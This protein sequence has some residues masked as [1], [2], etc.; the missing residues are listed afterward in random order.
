[1]RLMI[2]HNCGIVGIS[3]ANQIHGIA[4]KVV[5]KVLVEVE[6]QS[7]VGIFDRHPRKYGS[8]LNHHLRRPIPIPFISVH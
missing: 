6:Q 4:E 2:I 1:M 5:V 8:T 7:H 3:W